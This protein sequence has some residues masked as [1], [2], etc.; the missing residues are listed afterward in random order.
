MLPHRKTK[1]RLKLEDQFKAEV[2]AYLTTL[3]GLPRAILRL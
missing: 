2:I 3:G 1:R